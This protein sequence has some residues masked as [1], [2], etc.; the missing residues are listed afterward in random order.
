LEENIPHFRKFVE[1]CQDIQSFSLCRV[2][3]FSS[4]SYESFVDFINLAIRRILISFTINLSSFSICSTKR[5]SSDLNPGFTISGTEG[6]IIERKIYL[7]WLT[8]SNLV[9]SRVIQVL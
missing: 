9:K 2:S 5:I 3:S 6:L 7:L 4:H 8:E 1:I